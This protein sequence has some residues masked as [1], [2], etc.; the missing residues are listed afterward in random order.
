MNYV[1]GYVV[2]VPQERVDDY[3]RIAGKMAKLY[4]EYGAL[5][6]TEAVADDAPM[7]KVTSFPRAVQMADDETVFF[8]YITYRDRAHRDEVNT[9]VMADPRVEV[10]KDIP[11]DGKRMIWGGF[12]IVV[13]A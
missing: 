4:K 1:D 2:P 10:M 12:R 7:G 6:V 9:K 5:S 11:V 8:S 3:V 13:S